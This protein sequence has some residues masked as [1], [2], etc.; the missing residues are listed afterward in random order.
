VLSKRISSKRPNLGFVT[1]RADMVNQRGEAVFEL[2][3]TGMFL[4]RGNQA[5]AGA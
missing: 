4:T 2:Q 3:N 1:M 5:G